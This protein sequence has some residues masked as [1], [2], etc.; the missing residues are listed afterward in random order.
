[1]EDE[2][3]RGL[4]FQRLRDYEQDSFCPSPVPVLTRFEIGNRV[5]RWT[6]PGGTLTNDKGEI[7]SFWIPWDNLKVGSIVTPG[8]K[9][10]RIRH[11]NR[12]GEVGRPRDAV[13]ALFAV[14]DHFGPKTTLLVAEF[15]KPVW[16]LVGKCSGQRK[17]DDPDHPNEQWNVWYIGGEY[18]VVI[19]NLTP[20]WL[21]KM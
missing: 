7:T 18:Q 20:E 16:G 6:G 19:P 13:Q 2:L 17:L 8:F 12:G 21:K 11:Q 3:N 1:M 10:F 5:W 4:S 15:R 14:S 9:E